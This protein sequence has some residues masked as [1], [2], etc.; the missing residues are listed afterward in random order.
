MATMAELKFKDLVACREKRFSLGVE[1]SSG[2]FYLSVPVSNGVVDYEEYYEIDRETFGRFRTDPKSALGFVEHCR[3]RGADASL[4]V[5]P[6]RNR[7]TALQLASCQSRP[8]PPPGPACAPL[9]AS[10]A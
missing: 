5:K 6:G 9:V 4:I 7:G 1:E 3:N 2:K 8:A 10:E